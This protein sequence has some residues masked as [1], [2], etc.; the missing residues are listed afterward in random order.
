MLLATLGGGVDVA[1]GSRFAQRTAYRPPFFR[2]LGIKLFSFLVS[3][4]VGQKVFDTT[5]GF[6]AH[7]RR[8]ILLLTETFPH[9]YPE[10]EALI[11]MHRHG[12]RFAEVPVEMNYR[13]A[14]K[15]SIKPRHATYYMLKV[16]LAV[17]IAFSKR[18][19][20]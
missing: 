9:D 16:T 15:S 12:L 6:R 14:G 7:N 17:L 18:R 19:N 8:A 20:K 4:L 11:T 1:I 10:V 3:A 13:K 5:S 2:A